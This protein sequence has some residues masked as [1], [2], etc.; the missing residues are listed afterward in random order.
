MAG[1]TAGDDLETPSAQ[2]GSWCAVPPPTPP[3][4]QGTPAGPA[5][6]RAQ[7]QPL[8][9]PRA[10][11]VG[12]FRGAELVAVPSATAVPPA[13][14]TPKESPRPD[15]TPRR[16]EPLGV[17]QPP[18]PPV[19]PVTPAPPSIS[20]TPSPAAPPLAEPLLGRPGSGLSASMLSASKLS[21]SRG[22]PGRRNS[23]EPL[24]QE[25]RPSSAGRALQAPAPPVE[26]HVV[27]AK[28][29]AVIHF[30]R[31]PE[32]NVVFSVQGRPQKSLV[33]SLAWAVDGKLS[34]YLDKGDKKVVQVTASARVQV[35]VNLRDLARAADLPVEYAPGFFGTQG[36]LKHCGS[37]SRLRRESFASGLSDRS[38]MPCEMSRRDSQPCTDVVD[39]VSEPGSED[40]GDMG[41][42]A[43]SPQPPRRSSDAQPCSP[44]VV[45]SPITPDGTSF[46]P[47]QGLEGEEA[48]QSVDG[49]GRS[50]T[51]GSALGEPVSASQRDTLDDVVSASLRRLATEGDIIR[52]R[53]RRAASSAGLGWDS[54]AAAAAAAVATSAAAL[55]L[56]PAPTP[57]VESSPASAPGADSKG[58][59]YQE[60][61]AALRQ[62][63]SGSGWFSSSGKKKPQQH[64]SGGLGSRQS[65]TES[66]GAA[67]LPDA[68]RVS[69]ATRSGSMRKADSFAR[70]QGAPGLPPK[71]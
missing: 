18:V 8:F 32:G 25:G 56:Q 3:T 60:M 37:S 38:S 40:E 69:A 68:A 10:H 11:V 63:I 55:A 59:A 14:L 1:P 52:G 54:R 49:R 66:L 2:P 6:L 35:S 39:V 31:S 58:N 42:A 47:Q 46:A 71:G 29:G 27:S 20:P 21:V 26:V 7:T 50:A 51:Q 9:F 48:E 4:R 45:V 36:P 5:P 62:D 19:P 24:T 12:S 13:T 64:Q 61:L 17:P 41:C 16:L 67:A 33:R 23:L 34:V 30:N 28:T 22:V 43:V 70:R 53:L 44:D 57:P 65:S 15:G